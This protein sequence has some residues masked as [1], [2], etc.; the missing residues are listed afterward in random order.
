MFLLDVN[1]LV[2]ILDLNHLEHDRTVAW[3]LDH[4]PS[5][6]ATC[7]LTENGVV[8]VLSNPRYPNGRPV[9]ALVRLLRELRAAGDWRFLDDSLSLASGEYFLADRILGP[10]QITDTYLL[11]LCKATGYRLATL[12]RKLSASA[13]VDPPL[14]LIEF[15]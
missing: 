12:D 10:S 11:G 3:F 2:A 15:I 1:V 14:N 4:S 5:G 6:W 7:P 13:I 9:G 8:R